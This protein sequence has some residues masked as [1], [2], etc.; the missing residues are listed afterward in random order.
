MSIFR[1]PFVLLCCVSL[2]SSCQGQNR[3]PAQTQADPIQIHRFDEALLHWLQTDDS[4][5]Y[6]Q[7]QADYRP[8]LDVLGKSLF[9][10]PSSS[11]PG[12]QEKL[13]HY[14]AEP[15]LRKL[16]MDAVSRYAS[17]QEL[18]QQ[19]GEGFAYLQ[20]IFPD[21]TIPTCY[22]H[23]SGFNQ[24]VLVTDS[25]L[26]ISI[27]KYLGQDYP[28]YQ[29]FFYDYQMQKMQRNHV[30]P[31]YLTGWL[32]AEFPFEGKENVLL[33][34]MVYEGKLL[35]ILAHALPEVKPD[36]LLGYTPEQLNW[37]QSNEAKLWQTIVERKQLYTPDITTTN[38]YFE[39]AP[40]QFMANDAP[41][42]LGKWI[43]WQIVNRYMQTTGY[44]VVQLMQQH[45]A[46][47]LL[48]QAKYKP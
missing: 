6:H 18:Q 30:V 45:D 26:S 28:L 7:L 1:K 9:N 21:R 41:G 20:R 22:M 19:L 34:R 23:V 35:Y 37:L 10:L 39:E 47:T 43:G 5:A 24:N 3:V 25:L 40:S 31:D 38:L 17:I 46:Q 11:E 16:Y 12:Y 29:E 13:K 32:M 15:T 8:M 27:D 42:C 4:L 48:T 14:Y 2:L 44:T 33:D 36:T